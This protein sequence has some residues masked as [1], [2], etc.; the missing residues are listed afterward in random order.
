MFPKTPMTVTP[1]ARST[2]FTLIEIMIVVALM[3]ILLFLAYPSYT[4]YITRANRADAMISLEIVANEQEQFFLS[5]NTY[6]NNINLLPISALSREGHYVLSVG[7]GNV[8]GYSLFANPEA[9]TAS[10]RQSGDGGFRLQS[11]GNKRWDGKND[12]SY[13]CTWAQA[14][15]VGGC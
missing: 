8:L 1:P 14:S 10:G 7:A 12:G 5:N 9:V 15:S 4:G 3:V 2:G 6:A 11:N 13:A